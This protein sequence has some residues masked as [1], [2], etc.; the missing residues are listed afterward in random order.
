MDMLEEVMK[1][2]ECMNDELVS[3]IE[4]FAYD[5]G[6][7][8]DLVGVTV[9]RCPSC[10]AYEVDIPNIESLH[11]AVAHA[12]ARQDRPLDGMEIRFLRK[13]IGWSGKDFGKHFGVAPETVSRWETGARQMPL[14]PEMALR[15]WTL[16]GPQTQV[17]DSGSV[18]Q[19]APE[20]ILRTLKLPETIHEQDD[21]PESLRLSHHAA[22]WEKVAA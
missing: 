6:V 11:Q 2:L 19:I 10:D 3:R 14:F 22:G 4:T 16:V 5:C 12:V 21:E 1:C 17:Y 18:A 8:V 9:W 15:M 20:D 13:H 7:P